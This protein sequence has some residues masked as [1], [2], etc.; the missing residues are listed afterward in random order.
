MKAIL[1]LTYCIPNGGWIKPG[2]EDEQK[3]G[4]SPDEALDRIFG[5]L[6]GWTK[7]R[8]PTAIISGTEQEEIPTIQHR[9][10][11]NTHVKAKPDKKILEQYTTAGAKQRQ[12][13]ENVYDMTDVK[14]D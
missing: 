9:R 7:S 11:D 2:L 4:E 10:D 13:I 3:L 12:V 6:D 5:I 14:K 8:F 1:N